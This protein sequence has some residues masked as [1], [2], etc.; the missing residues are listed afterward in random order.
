MNVGDIEGETDRGPIFDRVRTTCLDHI[1]IS[2]TIK[3][4]KGFKE[5]KEGRSNTHDDTPIQ[6]QVIPL[7]HRHLWRWKVA[8]GEGV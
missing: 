7:S 6:S 3:R 1:P 4:L 2:D 5:P 8:R